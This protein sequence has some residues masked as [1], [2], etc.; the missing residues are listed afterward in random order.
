MHQIKGSHESCKSKQR[1]K[2]LTRSPSYAPAR[3]FP[4]RPSPPSDP[5]LELLSL[6]GGFGLRSGSDRFSFIILNH[7]HNW[8]RANHCVSRLIVLA[9]S[10]KSFFFN[11][12]LYAHSGAQGW[13]II[14]VGG[15]DGYRHSKADV[16]S[17]EETKQA[18]PRSYHLCTIKYPS[19]FPSLTYLLLSQMKT[20]LI[21]LVAVACV[22]VATP[23]WV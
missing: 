18:L 3:L 9:L 6:F 7:D 12:C 19:F 22:S 8:F 1:L 15:G 11:F 21:F 16:R 2:L 17:D 20:V 10:R 14:A 5:C 23:M 4:P 13:C